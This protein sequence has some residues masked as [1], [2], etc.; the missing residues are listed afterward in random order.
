MLHRI[1]RVRC[2]VFIAASCGDMKIKNFRL[3]S[4]FQRATGTI[5]FDVILVLLRLFLSIFLCFFCLKLFQILEEGDY[6]L[7]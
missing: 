2:I 7:F 3:F 4:V 1:K 5:V 6:L